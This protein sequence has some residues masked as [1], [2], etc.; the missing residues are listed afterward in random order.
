MIH[1]S[2]LREC[3]DVLETE[4]ESSLPTGEPPQDPRKHVLNG[5]PEE[6]RTDVD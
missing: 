6:K 2:I 1:P 3:A 5:R 4:A